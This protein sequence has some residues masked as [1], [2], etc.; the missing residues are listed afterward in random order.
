MRKKILKMMSS[1][2]RQMTM[3]AMIM[4]LE[5]GEEWCLTNLPYSQDDRIEHNLRRGYFGVKKGD[6][7]IYCGDMYIHCRRMDRFSHNLVGLTV[8]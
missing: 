8:L 1:G 4:S 2:D 3:L 6:I 7:I 5:K